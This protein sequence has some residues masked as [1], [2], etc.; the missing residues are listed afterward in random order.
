[1][2]YRSYNSELLIATTLMCDVFNDIIIDRRKHGLNKDYSKGIRLDE[3]VQQ[4]IEVPCILGDRGIVLKSLENEP[5]RYKLPLIIIQSKDIKTDSI[6]MCDLHADIFYQQ[7]SSFTELNTVDSKYRPI[8]LSKRRGQPITISYDVTFI[9]KYKED[10]DQ[11]I[12]NFVV[13]FRPDI[14]LKWWHPRIKREPLTSQLTWSH[15]ISIDSGI[16]YNPQNI[17]IYKGNTSFT[18]KS[19]L[20]YGLEGIENQIDPSLEPI[21]K[22]FSF[23]PHSSNDVEDSEND[24]DF[25]AFGNPI[26]DVGTFGFHAVDNFQEFTG[27]ADDTRM[28][29][30]KFAVNNIFAENYDLISGDSLFN[31]IKYQVE[32]NDYLSNKEASNTK[33]YK[34]HQFYLSFDSNIHINPAKQ[35]FIKNVHFK[36]KFN[37]DDIYKNSPSGDFLFYKFF[38][39]YTDSEGNKLKS[40]FGES[41]IDYG[42]L[43]INYDIDTKDF[44]LYSNTKFETYNFYIKS[45]FNSKN[46]HFTEM[47]LKSKNIKCKND[48]IAYSFHKEYDLKLNEIIEKSV[49]NKRNV[50]TITDVFSSLKTYLYIDNFEYK[51]A[52]IHI[53]NFI[54]KYWNSINLNET[55]ENQYK[56]EFDDQKA[57]IEIAKLDDNNLQWK[58]V[59]LAQTLFKD[60]FYYQVLTNKNIYIVLKINSKNESECDIYDFGIHFPFT[61]KFG[62]GLIYEVSIPESSELL[63]LNFYLG[64]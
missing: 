20:F 15:N 4:T 25:Y 10:L 30:G 22:N 53:H 23:F 44:T 9:T 6:R 57:S 1:M 34:E 17:H 39:E 5:G 52:L 16:D 54:K 28:L 58:E 51:L 56:I 49:E 2:K 63:G 40:E 29:S 37:K 26:K 11:I 64:L 18:F 13:H 45:N 19:W 31:N 8:E 62:A 41:F 27:N 35:C 60:G 7:D 48:F 59:K 3:I 32:N 50:K 24:D 46:G 38:K 36:S 61:Y 47:E 33:S 12:S 21:I 55:R 14:Y 43:N 42:D